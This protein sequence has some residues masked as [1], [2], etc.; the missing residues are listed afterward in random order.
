MPVLPEVASRMWVFLLI[1]PAFSPASIMATPIRSFTE[2]SG[3]KNSHLA[4]TVAPP[5]GTIRL[6]LTRGVLPMVLVMSAKTGMINLLI[7]ERIYCQI[8]RIGRGGGIVKVGKEEGV[9]S[10]GCVRRRWRRW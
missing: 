4:R 8:C 9:R 10:R 2:P 7:G 6:I 5:G 1:F 3:L